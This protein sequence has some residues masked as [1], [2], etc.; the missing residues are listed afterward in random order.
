MVTQV[1]WNKLDLELEGLSLCVASPETSRVI[2][3][4]CASVSLQIKW[5]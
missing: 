4:L 5:K 1:L 3:G 2:L